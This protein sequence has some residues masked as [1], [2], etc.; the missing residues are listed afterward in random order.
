MFDDV[1]KMNSSCMDSE[2]VAHLAAQLE[3][4]RIVV[5]D[6]ELSRPSPWLS[7]IALQLSVILL[8]GALGV[9]ITPFLL[10]SVPQAISTVAAFVAVGLSYVSYAAYRRFSIEMER[11]RLYSSVLRRAGHLTELADQLLQA[12]QQPSL[13]VEGR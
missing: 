4:L 6:L 11:K 8:L 10:P 12:V 7:F 3:E 9:A 1:S 5:H 13:I 2:L